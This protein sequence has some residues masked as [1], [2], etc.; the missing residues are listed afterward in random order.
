MTAETIKDNGFKETEIGLI[1]SDWNIAALGSLCN[2]LNGYAFRS[3]DY[4]EE[5]ILNFR[6]ININSDGSLDIS[7][8]AKYLPNAFV[9]DYSE[10]L[11]NEGDII[12]VMVGA[13]RGKLAY[14]TKNILPALMNQNMWRVVPTDGKVN[15]K[16]LYLFLHSVI[17][18]FME[19]YSEE[20][21]GFFK[22]DEFRDIRLT[23]PSL[24]EQQ[25]IASVLSKIQQAIEQ[26]DKIIQITKGLKKSLMNKFFSEGLHGE[27][28]KATEIGMIPKSWGIEN[29]IN[30]VEKTKMT[31]PTK[32]PILSFRY[33]DVSGISNESFRIV[34]YKT[35]KGSDA[36]SR[37]RKVI[38]KD[39]VIFA[40]VR[41]TLKRIAYI[42]DI[43]NG[44]ICSTAFCVLRSKKDVLSSR[45]IYYCV[46]REGFIE[47][48]SKLQRGASYP[49]ITDSDVK[50]QK[51]PLPSIEEQKEIANILSNVDKK[52]TQA[53][54]RKQ[55]LQALFKTM[56]NQ[57]MTG[58][59]RVKN[60]DIE[61]N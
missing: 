39:D 27:E 18:S 60:L 12:L 10:Y 30:I 42:E 19:K 40:T 16:Y 24:T 35:Y 37:A 14:I 47:E 43:F 8:D 17:N 20:T 11:L 52:I 2:V 23:L 38:N 57:L 50:R 46:Q 61:V 13:T 21:R 31:D 55:T 49:A 44:E 22:K 45:Y 33:I 25:K 56:L 5:G 54:V 32:N 26:Q 9:K 4:V 28:Q 58:N 41:P 6:I 7:K 1:P 48:L 36:P 59:A 53:E 3:E 34:E 51:I 29:I 15:R